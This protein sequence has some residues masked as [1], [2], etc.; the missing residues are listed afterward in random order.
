MAGWNYEK[1]NYKSIYAKNDNLLTDGV[2]N[3]N[4]A[5]GTDNKSITSNWTAYQFGGAFFR[6]NYAYDERYLLEFNGRYDASSRFPNDQRWAFFPSA[7]IGWRISQEPWFKIDPKYISNAK[8]RASWGELGNAVGLGNYQYKQ[9]LSVSTSDYILN[10][11]RQSY[12]SSPLALPSGLTW[13][14]ATTYDIGTD[15]VFFDNRLTLNADYYVRKTTDMIVAGPTVPDVFGA[16][17]P[18]GNY[19]DMSTTTRSEER[20]VGKECRSRWSPYH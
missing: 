18:R 17:S 15:L 20:R 8:L 6:L 11:L 12:M 14:T 4:L 2:E 13:E 7:S 1:S 5:M 10:G 9:V 3:I 16:S 19:A